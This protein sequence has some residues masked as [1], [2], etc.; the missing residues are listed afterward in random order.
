MII[1][2]E[3]SLNIRKYYKE[4]DEVLEKNNS[5][6]L[7]EFRKKIQIE[8]PVLIAIWLTEL[9]EKGLLTK[10]IDKPLENLYWASR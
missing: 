2:N 6:I 4:I 7:Q 10:E 5:T 3:L 8:K 9:K 1:M